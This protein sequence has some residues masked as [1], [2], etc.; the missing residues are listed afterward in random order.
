MVPL[1]DDNEGN[2]AV[3]HI[4]LIKGLCMKIHS[5]TQHH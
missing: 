2:F 5:V 4:A 1:A 3:L